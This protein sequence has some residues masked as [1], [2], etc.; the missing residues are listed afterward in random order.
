MKSSYLQA[1]YL[2]HTVVCVCMCIPCLQGKYP[3]YSTT[4]RM[5]SQIRQHDWYRQYYCALDSTNHMDIR[6]LHLKFNTHN[7][8]LRT[9]I[10]QNIWK[11]K[12]IFSSSTIS[13][14]CTIL[15]LIT[16]PKGWINL[17]HVWHHFSLN[18][19]CH[20]GLLHTKKKTRSSSTPFKQYL[21]IQI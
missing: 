17:L 13:N 18:I 8:Y 4:V 16:S 7:K 11:K 19:I 20:C 3:S 14:V 10:I 21:H 9:V 2:P 5:H 6:L 12:L 1:V 15:I